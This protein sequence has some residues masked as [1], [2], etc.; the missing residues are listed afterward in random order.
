MLQAKVNLLEETC[1][2]QLF[3]DVLAHTTK[4]TNIK[5]FL[6]ILFQTN[7]LTN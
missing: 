7:K 5:H 4:A 6:V 2:S 3:A 1:S